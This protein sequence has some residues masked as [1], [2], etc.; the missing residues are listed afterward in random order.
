MMGTAVKLQSGL[1]FNPAKDILCQ[2]IMHSMCYKYTAFAV[3]RQ[4]IKVYFYGK[5]I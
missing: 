3:M 4:S 5:E 2:Q 1:A